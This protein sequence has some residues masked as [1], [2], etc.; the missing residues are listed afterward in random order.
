MERASGWRGPSR[1]RAPAGYRG[2]GGSTRRGRAAPSGPAAVLLIGSLIVE[3]LA[4]ALG[5]AVLH[6]ATGTSPRDLLPERREPNV[7]ALGE[8]AVVGPPSITV[9]RIRT[10]L[11]GYDSPALPEA[12]VFHD[13]GVQYGIDPAYALAFFVVE[14]RA[15]TRGIARETHS[16]GNIRARAGEPAHEGYRLYASWREGIEDW[17]RLIAEVYVGEWGLTTIDAIAPVYA[18]DWDNND[19]A[20]YARAIKRLVAR[21]RGL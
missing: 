14:S 21:W 3:A 6:A 16:I 11:R 18:P 9:G 20:A 15:G 12:Q 2:K 8:G 19:T 13:L 7:A 10:I 17:Y 5:V 4:C 1:R